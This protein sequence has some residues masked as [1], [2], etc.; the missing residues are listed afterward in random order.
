M[1]PTKEQ[2]RKPFETLTLCWRLYN[3]AL[4]QRA[5][6]YRERGHLPSCTAKRTYCR[7]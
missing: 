3:A 1:K 5:M 7:H 6:G 2:E 4:E